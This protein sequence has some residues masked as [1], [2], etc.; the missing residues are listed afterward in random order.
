MSHELINFQNGPLTIVN[1]NTEQTLMAQLVAAGSIVGIT[2]YRIEIVASLSTRAVLPGVVTLRV[3][4]G[5]VTAVIVNEAPLVGVANSRLLATLDVYFQPGSPDVG[6]LGGFVL[7]NAGNI[8]AT[9]G[10]RVAGGSANIDLSIDNLLTA[11]WQFATADP[12]NSFTRT[13]ASIA[14]FTG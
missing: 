14:A 4:F 10:D 2:Q 13:L 9:P 5:A 11:T 3:R 6:T 12:A 8:F 7:Q 1:D